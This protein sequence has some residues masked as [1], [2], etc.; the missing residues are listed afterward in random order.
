MSWAHAGNYK[1]RLLVV[2]A[3]GISVVAEKTIAVG[4]RAPT[5]SFASTPVRLRVGRKVTFKAAAADADGSVAKVAW[6]LDGD[7][8]YD[9]AIG[10]DRDQD[11]PEGRPAKIGV[12][13]TD[14][15]G[16]TTT[17]RSSLKIAEQAML[18]PFPIVRISGRFTAHGVVALAPA[19][20]GAEG[21]EG[22]HPLPRPRLPAQEDHARGRREG[23]AGREVPALLELRALPALG[24]AP[25][26][27]RDQGRPDRQDH[28]DPHPRGP[29]PVA[30]GSLPG[31]AAS[32]RGARSDAPGRRRRRPPSSRARRSSAA[33]RS[34]AA[35]TRP[36]TPSRRA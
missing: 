11:L 33:R 21:I 6:D 2:D 31:A 28:P 30:L 26:D 5:A 3:Q 32:P 4:N 14:D 17:S 9:D 12:Q 34:P 24:H 13:V 35:T 29:R 15:L 19:G 20:R 7:N 27:P 8:K 23:R 18:N 1:V 25:R 22:E 16:A 36:P 10:H